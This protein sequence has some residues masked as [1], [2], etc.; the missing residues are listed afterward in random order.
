LLQFSQIE[1]AVVLGRNNEIEKVMYLEKLVQKFDQ[2]HI[3]NVLNYI[4]LRYSK[5][6][7]LG[8][9]ENTDSIQESNT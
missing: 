8:K 3:N 5:Y 6:I 4:D 1:A 2:T 9:S 7:Y